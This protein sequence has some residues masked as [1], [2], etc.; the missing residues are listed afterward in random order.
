MLVRASEST[1]VQREA[2]VAFSARM[3]HLWLPGGRNIYARDATFIHII[4][5]NAICRNHKAMHF[6]TDL[7]R[8]Y[9]ECPRSIAISFG[10]K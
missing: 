5:H 3:D 8:L 6:V 1:R 7:R 2:G 9:I 4:L 10:Y